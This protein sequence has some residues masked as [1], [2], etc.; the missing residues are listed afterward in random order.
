ML[1]I[2]F[3]FN[4]TATTEIYTLSYTTL[5][6]SPNDFDP[7]APT[8]FHNNGDGTFTDVSKSSGIGLKPANGL[9]VVTFDYDG[10]GWQ[11]MFIANDSLP[12]LLFRNNHDGTF[13]EV[14]YMAGVAVSLDGQ[15]EADRKSVV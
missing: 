2:F 9:G 4:D 8:L 1:S 7:V 6:R 10:D 15:P 12:N 5:F 14:G 11:D 13:T 3:F